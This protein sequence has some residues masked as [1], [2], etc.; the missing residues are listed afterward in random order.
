[1]TRSRTQKA[2]LNIV[3]SVSL[4]IVSI[5]S[6]LIIPRY[7]LQFF[8]SSYN[9]IVSSATQFMSL[10]S[11]LTLGVTAS[12]RAA[13]YK[14]LAKNDIAKTS[15]IVRATERYMRKIG[16][17]L[18][19][20]IIVLAAVYPLLVKTGFQYWDVALLILIVGMS[21]FAEYFFGITYQ[22]FLLADQCVYISNLFSCIACLLNIVISLVLISAGYGIHVVY[23]GS[24]VVYVLRPLLQNIYVTRK[25]KLDKHCAP[26]SSALKKRGDA[27]MHALSN[28]VHDNTDIV[29]LTL[30]TDVK[31]VSI[32]TIYNLVM[33]ALKKIQAIFTTGTEPIFGNMWARGEK[34]SIKKNL[35]VFEYFVDSFNAVAFSIAMVMVLP[36]VALY[37]P[38]NVNDINYIRPAYAIVIS[39][40]FA[41]QGMRVPYL[42]LVQGI[43]HYKETRNAAITEAVINLGVSVVLVNIIGLVGVAIGT[44]AA[45]LYRTFHY[46]IYIEKHV[47]VRGKYVFIKKF[48]WTMLNMVCIVVP[49]RIVVQ[50]LSIASW[51]QW[52]LVSCGV[53]IYAC[54]VL[55]VMSMLFYREDLK[56]AVNVA[57][58]MFLKKTRKSKLS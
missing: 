50:Q 5:I 27:M 14:T 25:Y 49:S 29:I 26:D 6:G 33:S 7:I 31:I 40:A 54:S 18:G 47:V 55:F 16:L 15:A 35:G 21:A 34:G 20:Y 44:L 56:Y 43:G 1:M 4:Q 19:G 13:L 2:S 36:F 46:A 23:F 51:S 32:Y 10:I 22:T 17:I 39:L 42:A 53:C 11:I 38:Q 30:F 3:T 48:L 57:M 24:A 28:I 41:T 8:G 12:T 45:N 58:R 9:G 37:V 52:V